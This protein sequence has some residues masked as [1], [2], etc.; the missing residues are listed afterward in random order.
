MWH[1]TQMHTQTCILVT[2]M[3]IQNRRSLWWP[4]AILCITIRKPQTIILSPVEA[5][6]VVILSLAG[7]VWARSLTILKEQPFHCIRCKYT[8]RNKHYFFSKQ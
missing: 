3:Q 2:V 8:R 1:A 6:S 7:G 4:I 5:A